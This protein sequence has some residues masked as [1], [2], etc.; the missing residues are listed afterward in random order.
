VNTPIET[1]LAALAAHGCTISSEG[2]GWRTPC[3]SPLH[4]HGNRK[5][6]A[7]TITEGTDGAVL[8]KC[9]AGCELDIV[10]KAVGLELKDLFPQC[11]YRPEK[12][13]A[14][15]L[16]VYAS[17]PDGLDGVSRFTYTDAN[18]NPVIYVT[19]QDTQGGKRIRQWGKSDCGSGWICSLRNAPKPRPFYRLPAI[20]QADGV[21]CIHEGEKAAVAAC[22]ASLHGIH[23]TA[24]G[25]AGN[26]KHTDFTPLKGRD[27][28]VIPDNDKPGEKHAQQVAALATAAGAQSV[29]IVRLPGLPEKGDV[30]EWLESGGNIESWMQLLSDARQIKQAKEY[31]CPLGYSCGKSGVF[32]EHED[33]DPERLTHRPVWVSALSRDGSRDNWGKLVQWVD[34]DGQQHE[35]AMPAAMFHAAGNELAQEMATAGLP[36]VPG[37]ERRLLQYLAA[38]TPDTRLTA[39]TATGWHGKSFIMPGKTI[40]ESDNERIIYQSNEYTAA[41]CMGEAGTLDAWKDMVR[42]VSPLVKFTVAASLAAPLRLLTNTAAGGF[43]FYATTSHGKTTILQAAASV[44]GNGADPALAGGSDVYIQ[45]WNAT[46][47]GLEGMAAS[48]NDLPLIVDEIGENDGREFGRV[49]YSI[50]S[51]TGKTRA[52][53]SGGLSKRRAWRVLLLSNGEL[54]VSDF[55]ENAK[56]GQLVRLVDIAAADMFTGREDADRMKHG[57]AKHYGTAGVAFLQSGDLLEGFDDLQADQIGDAPTAE[58]GRVRDR[59]RLV[60]HAGELAIKRGLL[61]WAAGDVLSACQSVYA[62]WMAKGNG[63]SDADRGIENVKAFL[64]AYGGSRF[65]SDDDRKRE[66]IDRAGVIRGDLY[67]FTPKGF[68]EA[69]SGVL[70]DTVKRALFGAG[71]LHTSEAGKMVSKARIDGVLTRVVSV[72]SAILSDPVKTGGD[73][74]DRGDRPRGAR[75]KAV[76]PVK[77][78]EGTRGT[79]GKGVPPVPPA[80]PQQGTAGTVATKGLSHL[81]HLSH[82]KNSNLEKTAPQDDDLP[83][84]AVRI[85]P[86]GKHVVVI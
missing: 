41:D 11:D 48:F 1:M 47:N 9:H 28:C 77:K 54:P 86:R 75:A 12:R 58:A 17:P 62:G 22:K 15:V 37:K 35:R 40:N 33:K 53:R 78:R 46:R 32:V 31:P 50:M 57:C 70:V 83:P 59:F 6:P 21:V 39:A 38:F 65:E 61:P 14:K 68:K 82:H 60:A 55:I 2:D 49:V 3:P 45:R 80:K 36:I 85:K 69:C 56:G 51:G 19:R 20:L 25:G 24:I 84:G 81:S 63:M 4:T 71:L 44:W 72:R 43:H 42:D 5:S 73:T 10:V 29:K 67:H 18:K 27:V 76:P 34:H 23:T 52:N 30:V 26:A 7:L 8:M 74:G 66:P 13:P 16:E 79:D 64:M